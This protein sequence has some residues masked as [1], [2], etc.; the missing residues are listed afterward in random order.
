MSMPIR[1]RLLA[2]AAA[3]ASATALADEASD[4]VSG[5]I[6]FEQL[7]GICHAVS[8]DGSGPTMGPNLY[9]LIGRKAG[10]EPNYAMYTSA[11]KASGLTWSTSTLDEFLSNPMA[12]IPGTSMVVML[13]S[14]K[15]RAEVIAYIASLE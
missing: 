2:F 7:C 10:T 13:Q 8:S 4:A 11:L 6:V 5:R 1:P 15:E 12:K 9:G 14:P 3:L